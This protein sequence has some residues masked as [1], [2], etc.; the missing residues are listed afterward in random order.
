M[1]GGFLCLPAKYP[2][3]DESLCGTNEFVTFPANCT[4]SNI[5]LKKVNTCTST[6]PTHFALTK[7]QCSKSFAFSLAPS[8]AFPFPPSEM[9]CT[10]MM[11][12]AEFVSDTPLLAEITFLIAIVLCI[13]FFLDTV[14]IVDQVP[15]AARPKSISF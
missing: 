9:L 7:L 1:C 10:L 14:I 3:I 11:L 12:V 6:N 15:P 8:F 13:F 5:N 4:I 2:G